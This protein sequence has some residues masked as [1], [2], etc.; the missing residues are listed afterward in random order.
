[1]T[2]VSDAGPLMALAKIGAL[3][4][5]FRLFPKILTPPAVH[6]E[7]ITEGLRLVAPDALLLRERYRS[8]ELE[9]LAPQEGRLSVPIRLG[10]GEE[11]SIQLAA[12]V[13]ATWLL[14]DDLDARRAATASLEAA[15]VKT[16]LKGTLGV[17]LSAREG[18]HL[19]KEEAVHFVETLRQ[20]PD[21]WISADLCA[22]VLALLEGSV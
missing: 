9:V 20:R 16:R 10:P 18:G 19:A 15:G 2:V 21:I 1:M 13:E 7:L 22:R 14:I 5:L 11:Q 8:G 3:D 17:I 12:E 4:P 6:H